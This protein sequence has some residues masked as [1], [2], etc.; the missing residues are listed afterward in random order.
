MTKN[1]KLKWRAFTSFLVLFSFFVLAFSGIILYIFPHGRVAYWVD[2]HLLGLDKDQ[3]DT[4][5]TCFSLLFVAFAVFHIVNNWRM[6]WNYAKDKAQ[7]TIRMKKEL[8]SAFAISV[9]FVIGSILFIPPFKS[10]KDFSEY[11]KESWVEPS[12]ARMP[13]PHAELQ[14]IESLGDRLGFD[15][16]EAVVDLKEAGL[17]I[18]HI[19][20]TLKDIADRNDT[21]PAAVLHKVDPNLGWIG[22]GKGLG[23]GYGKGMRKNDG[24][25]LGRSEGPFLGKGRYREIKKTDTEQEVDAGHESIVESVESEGR[26]LGRGEGRGL[27]RGRS[28]KL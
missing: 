1:F 24:Q 8:F 16:E 20:E 2:F 25:G 21:T 10:I 13:F 19:D 23:R 9:A 14:S 27:G 22:R 26:G 15:P 3:W 11:I 7:N 5:H 12:E 6:L 18:R 28:K 4:L 17:D